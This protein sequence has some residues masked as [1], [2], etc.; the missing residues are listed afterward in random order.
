MVRIDGRLYSLTGGPGRGGRGGAAQNALP[1]TSLQVLPT[2]TIYEFAGGGVQLTLTFLTPAL[3]DDLDVL[4]RPLTYIEWSYRVDR[5]PGARSGG[6]PGGRVSDLVVNTPDEPVLG[7]APALDG[8]PVLRDGLARAAGA[9]QARRRSAHRLGL[10]LSGGRSI[11]RASPRP[12]ATGSRCAPPSAPLAA[13]PIPTISAIAARPPAHAANGAG[14]CHRFRQSGR[15]ARLALP[16]DRLRR[17]LLHRIFR[18]PRARLVAAQ[19]RGRRRPAAHGP[20]RSRFAGGAR[21]RLRRAAH[22]RPAAGRRRTVRPPG[23]AGLP[24]DAGG[25]QTGGRCR[26]H[27]PCSS[28]RRISATAASPPWT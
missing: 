15:A 3:P 2:R 12:S 22:G 23:R 20:A 8:Q 6:L 7:L 24:A 11:R 19:R 9:G 5:W 13:C 18:A 10:P 4:S 21:Q 26:R 14:L 28:P 25:A 17:S 1:Q 16:D 27:A